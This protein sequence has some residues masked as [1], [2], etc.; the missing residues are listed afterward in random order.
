MVKIFLDAGHGGTDPGAVGNGLKEK[1]LTLKIVL[2][3]RDL[4]KGY[5]NVE[6][7]LSRDKDVFLELSERA[8]L[9]NKWKADYFASIHIN[10][11]GGTG[12]ETFIYNSAGGATVAHQNVIHQSILNPLGMKDRGKKRANF[13]VLRETKMSA[14]LSENGFIDNVADANK[15]KSDA[16]LDKIAQGHVE[17]FVKAFGL[18]KK[19][20]P[21]PVAKT[22]GKLYK[23][24]VGAYSQKANAEKVAAELKAKG[25]QT[26]IVHE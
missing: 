23:V 20:E 19:P 13:A 11:G 2:K 3:I 22:D 4:L 26:Y 7:K 9:V 16:F 14:I 8:D 6:T 5:E 21:R 15:L 24:Q 17:G 18:K 25:Y 10:A 1:D 12:F